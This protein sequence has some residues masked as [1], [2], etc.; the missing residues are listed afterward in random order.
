MKYHALS[1][2][3]LAILS[4]QAHAAEEQSSVTLPTIKVSAEKN[5]KT[6]KEEMTQASTA[7]KGLAQLKDVPQ[8]VNVIPQEVLRD[9]A[10]TSL[11]QAVLNA[12]G[13]TISTGDGQRDQASIR[14]FTSMSDNY[15]DG[16]RDDAMYYRDMSNVE[17]VEVVQGPASVLY[18]RGS[19]GGMINRIN[20]KPMDTERH[21]V[22]LMGSTF[23]QKR[24]E[25]DLNQPITDNVKARLTG[26]VEDSD[27]YKD[28]YFLKRQA[29]APSVEWKLSDKTKLLFQ[30]DYLHDDRLMDVGAPS[31]ST[32]SKE[33]PLK[34]VNLA[35]STYLGASNA[36]DEN[37]VD[38]EVS[39]GTIT[40][41]HQF[42]DSLKYH[43]VV[44]GYQYDLDRKAIMASAVDPTTNALTLSSSRLMRH[45]TGISTQ[46]ELSD[47]FNTGSIKHEAL[48]G[49]EYSHQNK[50]SDSWSGEKYNVNLNNLVLPTF[51][52]ISTSAP[53]TRQDSTNDNTSIYAQDL[54]T[55]HPK[56]KMLLGVRYD[57]LSQQRTN[58]TAAGAVNRQYDRTDQVWSPRVGFIYQPTDVL[59]LYTSYSK[60][61]QPLADSFSSY[62]NLGDVDPTKTENYEI[63]AKWDVTDQFNLTLSVFDTTQNNILQ[64]DPTD[65]TIAILAGEQQTKGA[66]LSFTGN[67]TDQLSIMGGYAY[68]DSSMT[69]SVDGANDVEGNRA[70]LTPK[71]MATF[72][73]KYQLNDAWYM[74]LGGRAESSRFATVSNKTILP[75]Y[76]VANAAVG[77]HQDKYDIAL[78]INNIFDNKYF[79]SAHGVGGE[80]AN[81]YGDAANAQLTLR[82][83]F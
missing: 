36:K 22:T 29:V 61:F 37:D 20:K 51:S 44:H 35:R 33:N 82:Y 47:I 5:S 65:S 49:L 21:E 27:G 12:P 57:D 11:Q 50:S 45:E 59:S 64:A 80:N 75:G 17:R 58:L 48:L 69:K 30:A 15:V 70:P 42:T 24:A 73:M 56:F 26:A 8:T 46:H 55:L 83:R 2:S 67:L 81:M 28:Q 54:L 10:V 14:G 3:I 60:S 31:Y 25:I 32:S 78:N 62:L 43:G 1:L 18:G 13:V 6:L 4:I 39:S 16:F 40:L 41:D 19:A 77:Y 7:T 9:Q 38:S 23:G 79:I 34:P 71:N 76:A 53:G 52:E 72:W 68:L 66:E 63:G 74:A